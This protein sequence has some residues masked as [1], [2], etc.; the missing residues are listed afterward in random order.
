MAKAELAGARQ[1]RKLMAENSPRLGEVARAYL[2]AGR[3]GEALECLESSRDAGLLK[4][5]AAKAREEGDFWAFRQAHRLLGEE[6]P[7][8][9]LEELARRAQSLGKEAYAR[10]AGQ[11]GQEPEA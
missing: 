4:E 2:E 11:A 6:M 1:R 10:A 7:A 3:L 8:G 9:E 5:L